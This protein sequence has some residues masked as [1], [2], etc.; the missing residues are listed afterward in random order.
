MSAIQ[1]PHCPD[2]HE[3]PEGYALY[4]EMTACTACDGVGEDVD[5]GETWVCPRCEGTGIDPSY[6]VS[7]LDGED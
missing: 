3:D 4:C 5:D 7:T 1:V 6:D 2:P